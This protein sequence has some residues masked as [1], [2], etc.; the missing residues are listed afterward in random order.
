MR[1]GAQVSLDSVSSLRRGMKE[2]TLFHFVMSPKRFVEVLWSSNALHEVLQQ[3][4]DRFAT[5]LDTLW[6]VNPHQPPVMQIWDHGWGVFFW[7]MRHNPTPVW[8]KRVTC[9]LSL[10]WHTHTTRNTPHAQSTCTP[11]AVTHLPIADNCITNMVKTRHVWA[12][13]Q[14]SRHSAD[15]QFVTWAVTKTLVI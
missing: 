2:K 9:S 3:H 10:W 1:A 15:I 14:Y 13:N 11:K 5:M 12:D 6:F 7:K 8:I 4:K